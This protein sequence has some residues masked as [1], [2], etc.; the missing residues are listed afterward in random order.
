MPSFLSGV[1]RAVDLGATFTQYNISPNGAIADERALRSDWKVVG[2]DLKK[3]MD[4]NDCG[5]SRLQK[6]RG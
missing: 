5:N 3:A 4:Q 2:Q 6:H 1:A